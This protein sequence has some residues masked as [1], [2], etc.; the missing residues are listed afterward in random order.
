[1]SHY[2]WNS[3]G[4]LQNWN[5]VWFRICSFDLLQVLAVPDLCKSINISGYYDS[6]FMLCKVC[7][8]INGTF[9]TSVGNS[10]LYFDLRMVAGSKTH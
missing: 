1:M 9:S 7:E 6:S 2:V 5:S 3:S 8:V 4:P 10:L